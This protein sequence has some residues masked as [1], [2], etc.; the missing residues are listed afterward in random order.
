MRSLSRKGQVLCSRHGLLRAGVCPISLQTRAAVA[1]VSIHGRLAKVMMITVNASYQ[2]K[3]IIGRVL[4]RERA[5]YL[6]SVAGLQVD[7]C[8]FGNRWVNVCCDRRS[9][10]IHPFVGRDW[11]SCIRLLSSVV[12]LCDI[13]PCIFQSGYRIIEDA[14]GH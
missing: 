6:V 3:C 10:V 1:L 14:T 7:G 8:F 9:P 4:A 11:R 13:S 2:K 12:W 5:P